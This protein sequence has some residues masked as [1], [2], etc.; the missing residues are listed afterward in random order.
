MMVECQN[1]QCFIGYFT[2]RTDGTPVW[3]VAI[4]QASTDGAGFDGNLIEVAGGPGFTTAGT[5]LKS[6]DRGTISLRFSGPDAGTMQLAGGTPVAI[7]RFSV[8]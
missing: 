3:Y 2:Y 8:F 1:A 4:G 6:T 5:T 7:T